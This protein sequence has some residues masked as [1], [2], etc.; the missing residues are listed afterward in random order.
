MGADADC[1]FWVAR[2]QAGGCL[3]GGC[4]GVSGACAH[5]GTGSRRGAGGRSRRSPSRERRRRRDRSPAGGSRV[6]AR[7]GGDRDRRLSEPRTGRSAGSARG[8]RL[9]RE[10]LAGS[11]SGDCRRHRRF[12]RRERGTRWCG[13]AIR[14][15]RDGGRLATITSDAAEQERGI[16]VSSV[17]VRADGGQLRDLARLL[18]AGQLE[19]SIATSYELPDAAA[20]L[21]TVVSGR[22]GGAVALRL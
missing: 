5:R 13:D 10:A 14:A 17:Y 22:A 21:A 18:E 15:V 9:P 2:P 8:H 11:R 16:T 3:L 6:A 4:G 12:R 1:A 19:I 7:G 20:A